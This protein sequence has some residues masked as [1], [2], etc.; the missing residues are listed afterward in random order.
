M[1]FILPR[2]IQKIVSLSY[3]YPFRR[4]F[5]CPIPGVYANPESIKKVLG[6][7]FKGNPLIQLKGDPMLCAFLAREDTEI[8]V[9]LV[10]FYKSVL[11]PSMCRAKTVIG[12]D[13]DLHAILYN[14]ILRCGACSRMLR[15]H[16]PFTQ[17]FLLLLP[18][19]ALPSILDLNQDHILTLGCRGLKIGRVREAF[20]ESLGESIE[21]CNGAPNKELLER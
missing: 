11:Y 20:E 17:H 9:R 15:M 14:N 2:F 5:P 4:V 3:S 12:A 8:T 13:N 16:I 19:P 10:I 21:R 1:I 6:R 7:Y 18:H